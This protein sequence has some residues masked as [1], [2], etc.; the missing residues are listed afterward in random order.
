[1]GGA[2][3]GIGGKDAHDRRSEPPD[4]GAEE[5]V[6]DKNFTPKLLGAQ[7]WMAAGWG[8]SCADVMLVG[9]GGVP[10]EVRQPP[11]CSRSRARRRATRRESRAR[12]AAAPRSCSTCRK[13]LDRFR[14]APLCC[15]ER[16]AL[17]PPNHCTP[18]S[19]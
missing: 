15:E 4:R 14:S 9:A 6:L 11:R 19:S 16:A 2:D 3:G 17:P 12:V 1:M 5:H 7:G 10:G 13:E 8:W 18:C